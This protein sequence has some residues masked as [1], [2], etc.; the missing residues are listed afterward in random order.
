MLGVSIPTACTRRSRAS[1]RAASGCRPGKC[2]AATPSGKVKGRARLAFRFDGLDI[3][4][5]W[6]DIQ[7]ETLSYEAE[8]TKTEDAKKIGIG[9]GAGAVKSSMGRAAHGESEK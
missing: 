1:Q 6:Y 9:A 5:D 2:R 3:A 4:G 8:G 7:S